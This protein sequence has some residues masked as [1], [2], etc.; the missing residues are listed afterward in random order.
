M[1]AGIFDD[2]LFAPESWR[3][4]DCNPIHGTRFD[5]SW[6]GLYLSDTD[7]E[8]FWNGTSKSGLFLIRFNAGVAD[9]DE[10]IADSL[11]YHSA[12]GRRVIVGSDQKI[13]LCFYVESVLATHPPTTGV[14]ANDARYVV[15]STSEEN[16]HRIRSDMRLKSPNELLFESERDSRPQPIHGLLC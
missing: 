13:D 2:I 10:R 15:H 9:L 3:P 14:R 6:V 12:A 4:G 8:Q 1:K 11:R 5:S 16:W 7:D